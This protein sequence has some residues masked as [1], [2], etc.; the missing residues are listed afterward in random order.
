MS[1]IL[2]LSVISILVLLP[3]TPI[4]LAFGQATATQAPE[5]NIEGKEV[6][7]TSDVSNQVKKGTAGTNY[8]RR[9]TQSDLISFAQPKFAA[10]FSELQM[11][12][13]APQ[14]HI[15]FPTSD[16]KNRTAA[17]KVALF[18]Q[19]EGS[20]EIRKAQSKAYTH[21]LVLRTSG[22]KPHVAG[23]LPNGNSPSTILAIYRFPAG[24]GAGVIAIVDAF[25]YPNAE[26]DL[27]VFSKTFGLPTCT[28]ASGCLKIIKAASDASLDLSKM[29]TDC[30]WS[31][32]A[33]LDLQW[34]HAIAPNAKLVFVQA[35]SNNN[36][37]LY[38]AVAKATDA[39]VEAGGGQI[40]MSWGSDE[41]DT[42]ANLNSVF[43]SGVLYFASSGDT[44][45]QLEYPAA[46]PAVISV[47]GTGFLRDVTGKIS[48]QYGWTGSGGGVSQYEPIS[49]VQRNVENTSGNFRNIPDI[50]ANADPLSGVAV[51]V[52]VPVTSCVDKPSPDQYQ[53]GWNVIGGTSLATPIIAAMTNVSGK[54]RS[55]VT[56]ELQAIYG[57]RQNSSRIFDV[58]VMDGTAGGNQI[59]V[60]YDN[61]TGVG[62]PAGP[63]FDANPT[64]P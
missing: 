18:L 16:R 15:V 29:Q 34:A 10:S 22:A 38:A 23:T 8:L 1:R 43:K 4:N 27:N 49:N 61:V 44:G 17:A 35:N 33:A 60:G 54:R 55:S 9:K 40:S 64:T 36:N 42:D 13:L 41:S 24:G 37:D 6:R 63:D 11:P 26:S 5:R 45:G 32:E 19:T 57:N 31:T 47:G 46:S 14:A 12:A 7:P 30:G 2:R 20:Q 21:F 53:V 28:T 51:Y 50:S 25:N 59:K 62:T 3:I 56:D 48:P 52:S 58:T 39:V